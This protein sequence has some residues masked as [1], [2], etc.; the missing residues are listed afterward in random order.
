MKSPLDYFFNLGERV[1]HGDVKRK[2]KF[3][4]YLLWAMFL[5]FFSVFISNFN[6]F[7]HTFAIDFMVSLKYL[8]WSGIMLAIMWFQYFG[9]KS[10]HEFMKMINVAPK[11]VESK[12]EMLKA[13]ENETDKVQ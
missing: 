10:A 13:F 6:S 7:L 1:T 2:A 11:P 4:Y 5:A 3:D 9:L 12:E 8:G